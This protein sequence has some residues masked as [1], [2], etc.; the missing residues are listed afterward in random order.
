MHFQ[1][2]GFSIECTTSRVGPKFVGEAT[3][4]RLST[5]DEDERPFKSGY[6]TSFQSEGQA[7]EYARLWAEMWC[8][9]NREG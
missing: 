4:S 9:E 3:I 6:L 1:H 7:L 5:G 8:D 2:R